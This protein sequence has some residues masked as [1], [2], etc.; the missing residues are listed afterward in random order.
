M[1]FDFSQID[2]KNIYKLLISTV[3]PRPIAFVT[4]V[5]RDGAVNAAPFS[6]FNAMGYDPPIVVIG[7]EARPERAL[8]DTADNIALNGE[9]VVHVVDNVI[10]EA[11]NVCAIDFGPEVDE[12][13]EA[14]LTTLPALKVAPPRIAEAPVA[15]E[16]RRYVT[17]ELGNMRNIVVGEVLHMHIRDDLVIDAERCH[18][19]VAKLDAVGRLNAAAYARTTDRFEMP[20]IPVEEWWR[21]KK[22]KGAAE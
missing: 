20:R 3:V 5:D 8:K 11:M 7:I 6:F 13:A 18:I 17:L 2:Q 15:M 9:F 16:C 12:L 22:A 4:T 21:N 1:E 10:A 19:D 14:G